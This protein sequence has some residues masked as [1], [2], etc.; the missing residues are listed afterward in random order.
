MAKRPSKKA[1]A[2]KQ[3]ATLAKMKKTRQVDSANLREIIKAKLVWVE[4]ELKKGEI[5][6]KGLEAQIERLKPQISQLQ[7]IKLFINDLLNPQE[8]TQK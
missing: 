5:H 7:G 1:I 8:E 2:K 3:K 4:L 6:K